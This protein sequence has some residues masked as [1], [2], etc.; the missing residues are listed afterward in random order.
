VASASR[1]ELVRHLAAGTAGVLGVPLVGALVPHDDV[2]PGRHDV[3][4]AQRLAGVVHRLGLGLGDA[5]LAGLPGRRVLLVDDRVGTGWTMTV[6]A[7][8]LRQHGATDVLPFA[9]AVG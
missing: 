7:R 9:L 3:N 4:S 8:L 2:P 6:G 5:A 1:P